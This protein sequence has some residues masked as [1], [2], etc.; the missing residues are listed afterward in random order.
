LIAHIILE[1]VHIVKSVAIYIYVHVQKKRFSF[2]GVADLP[3]CKIIYNNMLMF[4]IDTSL[5][6][7]S[8]FGK[9]LITISAG[10]FVIIYYPT[11]IIE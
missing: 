1:I 3:I 9:F 4:E 11:G 2:D 5:I 7:E 8:S 6:Y 10:K